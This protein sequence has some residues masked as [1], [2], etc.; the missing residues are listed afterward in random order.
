MSGTCTG[1]SVMAVRP[2]TPSPLRMRAR[3][4]A[5]ASAVLPGRRPLLELLG[6]LVVLED[7]AAVEARELHGARDDG[8]EHRLEVERRADTACPTSP[9]A[10]SWPTERW[11]SA[12]RA[13][14]SVSSRAFSTAMTAWSAKVWSSAISVGREGPGLRA[15]YPDH[16]DD[17]VA[18]QHRHLDRRAPAASRA[19]SR[20]ARRHRRVRLHVDDVLHR[21]R[22]DGPAQQAV[23]VGTRRRPPPLQHRLAASRQAAPRRGEPDELAVVPQHHHAPRAEQPHRAVRDRLEHRL[24]VGLRLADDAQDVGGGRLPLQRLAEVV[25]ARLQLLEQ[26][27]VLDGDDRLVGEGLEQRD[28]LVARTGPRRVRNTV[29]APIGLPSRSI[30]TAAGRSGARPPRASALACRRSGSCDT[31]GHVDD[32]AIEDGARRR[33]P[34]G[35]AAIGKLRRDRP[36]APPAG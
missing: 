7:D 2:T 16:P 14:S 26:A 30:G 6:R 22:A 33:T 23:R 4:R 8:R 34:G 27:H 13:C 36:P 31:S 28:L 29:I 35:S 24:H 18:P 15:R 5:S 9:S 21:P 25:V 1:S 11:S 10:V 12:V 3:R 17:V 19:L 32:G 20:R